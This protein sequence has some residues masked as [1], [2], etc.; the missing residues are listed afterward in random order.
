MF[1]RIFFITCFLCLSIPLFCQ[2]VIPDSQ[3]FD[4][5]LSWEDGLYNG[6]VDQSFTILEIIKQKGKPDK[7]FQKKIFARY[8]EAM[9]TEVTIEPEDQKGKGSFYSGVNQWEYDPVTRTFIHIVL[10]PE[11]T[12]F[13]T[14]LPLD[15]KKRE[16]WYEI[17]CNLISVTEESLGKLKVYKAEF[18]AK[19]SD[20]KAQ[21]I[22]IYIDKKSRY[23]VKQ[24]F[25]NKAGKHYRS[26]YY[27]DYIK[28]PNSSIICKNIIRV[29]HIK[30][31]KLIHS[32]IDVDFSPIPDRVFSKT[33]L[34]EINE[35]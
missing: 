19:T 30:K 2:K 32:L 15:N 1:K 18:D 21:K 28:G 7:I 17:Y 4:M 23:I 6:N 10:K 5:I 16:T 34:E 8:S 20:I 12:F 26:D 25:Y 24:E 3:I 31:V 33:Y 13:E 9:L 14:P 35:R 29:D 22:I 11:E 27:K